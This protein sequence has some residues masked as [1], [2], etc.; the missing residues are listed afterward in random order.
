MV[1]AGCSGA[2]PTPTPTPAAGGGDALEN[3]AP[4]T[5]E[6]PN[7]PDGLVVGTYVSPHTVMVVCDD[8][9]WCEQQV[10]DTMRVTASRDDTA[11]VFIE[12]VQ[13]N[14]H[15]CT[16]EGTLGRASEDTWKWK[17]PLGEPEC[18]LTLVAGDDITITSEGCREYCGAR[19]SLDAT[20][21]RMP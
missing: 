9:D 11:S 1:L 7:V 3:Q 13:A 4:T 6:D 5:D 21:P 17:A 20:F 19:A 18:V 15:S 12:L 16:F 14:A 10:E 8:P 2:A